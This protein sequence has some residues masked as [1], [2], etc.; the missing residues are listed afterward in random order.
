MLVTSILVTMATIFSLRIYHNDESEPVTGVWAKLAACFKCRKGNKQKKYVNYTDADHRQ[1][2]QNGI[3]NANN[4]P[5][6]VVRDAYMPNVHTARL[7]VRNGRNLDILDRR[8]MTS[9][10]DKINNVEQFSWKDVSVAIDK[11]FFVFFIIFLTVATVVF[12][13]IIASERKK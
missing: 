2:R 4:N 9:S 7:Q 5:Y 8:E 1:V 6:V 13:A 12:V 3:V 11:I 10:T